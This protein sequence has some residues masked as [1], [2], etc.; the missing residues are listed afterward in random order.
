M[1]IGVWMIATDSTIDPVV[2]AQRAEELGFHSFWAPEQLAVPVHMETGW[3]RIPGEPFPDE[4]HKIMDPFIILSRVSSATQTIRLGTG[5]CQVPHR[6][7]LL[8]GKEVATLDFWSGGRVIF[9]IGAAWLREESEL[10]G[11]DFDRRWGWTRESVLAMKEL[12]TKD[13]AEFH[14]T[15]YDFPAVR[16]H[17]MPVQSPHP[18]ILIGSN[19]PSVFKK[20]VAW[21][22]GWLPCGWPARTYSSPTEIRAG[23]AKLDELAE[24]A[25]RDPKSI[26]ITVFGM[27][28]ELD[29]VEEHEK[30]GADEV[31]LCVPSV[32]EDEALT[33][34]ER[35]AERTLH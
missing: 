35:L 1:K 16:P 21:A 14:G 18:P 27:E 10:V 4:Y 8:L 19:S 24:A 3:R 15:Y 9:G 23:R 5:V 28:T 13:E 12:W 6:H 29:L 26:S 22:D 33:E 30:A 34:L 17:P 20:I 32:G 31:V 25:G 7:P 11:V 2:L